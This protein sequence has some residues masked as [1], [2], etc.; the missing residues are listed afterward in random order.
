[1]NVYELEAHGEELV[2]IDNELFVGYNQRCFSSNELGYPP[3]AFAQS[4]EG[5]AM[6]RLKAPRQQSS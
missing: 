5:C 4:R 3:L 1:M 6:I 2:R